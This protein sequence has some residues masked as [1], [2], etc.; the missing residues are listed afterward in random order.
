MDKGWELIASKI[1]MDMR[2]AGQSMPTRWVCNQATETRGACTRGHVVTKS[3]GTGGGEPPD[4]KAP[5]AEQACRR[6]TS[7]AVAL[8]CHE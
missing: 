2:Y 3:S 8:T 6:H 5:V 7:S 1:D 4:L